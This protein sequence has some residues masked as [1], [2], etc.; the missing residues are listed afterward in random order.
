MSSGKKVGEF[1]VVTVN[2]RCVGWVVER[3]PITMG[4]NKFPF[5]ACVPS[6]YYGFKTR[7]F[8]SCEEG[9]VWVEEHDETREVEHEKV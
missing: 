2:E 4:A 9:E 3:L 6:K 5:M 7:T 8:A 1:T